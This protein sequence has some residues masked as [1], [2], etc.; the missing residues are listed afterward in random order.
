MSWSRLLAVIV[1][2]ILA[3]GLVAWLVDSLYRLYAGVS[4]A[5]P[6]LGNL[7]LAF[8]LL[9]LALLI[10]VVIYY[11]FLF[12]RPKR[13]RPRPQVP[14]QRSEAAKGSLE[15]VRQQATQIQDEIARQALLERSR[16]LEA[17]FLRREFRL[18]VFGTGSAG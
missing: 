6:F 7:L 18:V 11:A 4:L 16:E 1:G 8:L 12:G 15:A 13:Q 10:A 9:L 14:V 5:S 2:I 17:S 3:L